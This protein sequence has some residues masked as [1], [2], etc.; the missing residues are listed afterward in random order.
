MRKKDT[1]IKRTYKHHILVIFFELCFYGVFLILMI[2]TTY[3]MF[4]QMITQE[5][6]Q[7]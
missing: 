7:Y 3:F 2:S 4:I 5:L 1:N 6:D